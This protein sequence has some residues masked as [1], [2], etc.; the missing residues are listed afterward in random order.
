MKFRY[1]KLLETRTNKSQYTFKLF[2]VESF[3][4]FKSIFN[5]IKLIEN[6]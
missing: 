6:Y 1:Q 4:F 5:T 3:R 2:L